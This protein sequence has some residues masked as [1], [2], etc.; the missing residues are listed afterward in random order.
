MELA[1]V[2]GNPA[3]EICS[4]PTETRSLF[5]SPRLIEKSPA[6]IPYGDRVDLQFRVK[7]L[8]DVIEFV[9]KH[10]GRVIAPE[11]IDNHLRRWTT[12]WFHVSMVKRLEGVPWLEETTV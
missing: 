8:K 6:T 9:L 1:R 5:I 2:W 12:H 7:Y 3:G 11:Q 10:R 4:P